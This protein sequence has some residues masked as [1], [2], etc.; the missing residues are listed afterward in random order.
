MDNIFTI[1]KDKEKPLPLMNEGLGELRVSKTLFYFTGNC[2]A[3]PV[4]QKALRGMHTRAKKKYVASD[5]APRGSH[6]GG[7]E[8]V[9]SRPAAGGESCRAGFYFYEKWLMLRHS[10]A[11][12]ANLRHQAGKLPGT[13]RHLLKLANGRNMAIQA[14]VN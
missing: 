11:P 4:K 13:S 12:H 10:F 8:F 9:A 1:K 3:F 7:T 6:C 2:I 14:A 5:R